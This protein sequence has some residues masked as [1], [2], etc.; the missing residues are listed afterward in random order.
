MRLVYSCV[1]CTL[2]ASTATA[3]PLTDAV[4]RYAAQTA[5]K[6]P[7]ANPDLYSGGIVLAALGGAIMGWGLGTPSSAVTCTSRSA[8][9]TCEDPSANKGLY[10]AAGGGLMAA[11][12]AMSAIGGKRVVVA[13]AQ[14]R[15]SLSGRIR[16]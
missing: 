12:I 6:P 3:G 10:I 5:P 4:S 8:S 1:L 16:F 11:G 15:V 13:A 9:V 2:M 7:R 14:E